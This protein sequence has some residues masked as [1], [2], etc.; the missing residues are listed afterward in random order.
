MRLKRLAIAAAIIPTF[1]FS[2]SIHNEPNYAPV[3]MSNSPTGSGSGTASVTAGGP[4]AATAP[5]APATP[6][7]AAAKKAKP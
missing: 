2:C 1:G 3:G 5:A 6:A 4:P 7:P